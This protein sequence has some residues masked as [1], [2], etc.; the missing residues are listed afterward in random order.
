MDL[1]EA[2]R[3]GLAEAAD[4]VKAEGMRA[5]MKSAMPF[6]GVA[7]P[8]RAKLARAL[9]AA[10]PM[11][12]RDT[13]RATALRLWREAEYREERYLAL[14]LTGAY[15]RWQDVD[16]LPLY[17]ELVVTGAWWDFVD[18]VA[19]RRVGPLLRAHPAEV[20]AV[21]RTWSGDADRW[22]RRTS[23]IC[24]LG[25]RWATD[26]D[27]LTDCVE[28]TTADPDFFLRKAIGWA[29]RDYAKT[30]PAWVR[31]F[32]D[33]HPALSPLSRREALKHLG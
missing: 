15:R 22:R 7:K 12:D 9:F 3:A 8:E 21:M 29:L 1:V 24:Q 23:V 2:A 20:A 28:A 10:H 31:D 30:D 26:T 33:T 11:P 16:L 13:W 27:L 19:S 14:D 6:R 5:Y 4:P 25:A 17:D 18:E 32:V